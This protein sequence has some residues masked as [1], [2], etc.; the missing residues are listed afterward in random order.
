MTEIEE[1]RFL[2]FVNFVCPQKFLYNNAPIPYNE[3]VFILSF[4]NT[5]HG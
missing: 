4:S 3:D 5:Y 2:N 1:S